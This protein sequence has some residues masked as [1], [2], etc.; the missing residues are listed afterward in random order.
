M[1]GVGQVALPGLRGGQLGAVAAQHV[2]E[3]GDRLAQAR[4]SGYGGAGQAGRVSVVLA[5]EVGRTGRV[6]G[7]A[8]CLAA[9]RRAGPGW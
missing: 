6:R 9:G 8:G 2:G 7:R 4:A 1:V 3:H 5:A